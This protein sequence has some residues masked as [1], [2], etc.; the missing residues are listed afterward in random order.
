[1]RP[2]LLALSRCY[3]DLKGPF[4]V[5]TKCYWRWGSPKQIE[6]K[7][8]KNFRINFKVVLEHKGGS[9]ERKVLGTDLGLLCLADFIRWG[10]SC[11]FEKGR[12]LESSILGWCDFPF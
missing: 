11:L 1:M 10:H 5:T 12:F 9:T 2:I 8:Q 3:R 4:A 6:R 7:P